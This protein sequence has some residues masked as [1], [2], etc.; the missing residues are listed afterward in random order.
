MGYAYLGLGLGGAIAPLLINFLVAHYGWRSAIEILGGFILLVLLP[1]GVFITRSDPSDVGLQP[2]GV[3]AIA[4]PTSQSPFTIEASVASA[5]RSLNFWLILLGSTLVI[6]AVGAVIQ[7]FVLFLKD[8]GYSAFAAARYATALM[9]SS[10][11]GRVLVGYAADRFHKVRTMSLF[12][13][14]IGLDVFLLSITHA[15]AALWAI[16]ALF[17]FAM[18]ADYMLISLV[19]A[20]CFGTRSLGKILALIIAG[21]SLGQWGAPLLAGKIFDVRHSYDLAWKLLA[22]AGVLGAAA[23]YAI[24]DRPAPPEPTSA[25]AQK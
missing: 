18:G 14:L 15:P 4:N 12:Y 22:A 25:F 10:L 17:G 23:I 11:A 7:H 24:R 9:I 8:Q 16:A 19:T 21:Y 1:V 13:F 5:I 2:Y 3:A 20:E 6:G